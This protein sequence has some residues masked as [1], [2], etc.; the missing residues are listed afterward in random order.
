MGKVTDIA[1]LE[2]LYGVPAKPSLTKVADHVT[3][4]YAKW[5]AA[6]RLCILSTVG[7]DGTNGSPR[8]DDG[9]VVQ[10]ADP[11]TLLMPDWRGNNRMDCLR[12][13]VADGR[14]SLMFIVRGSNNVIRVNGTAEVTI[15]A[16]VIAGFDDR[17]R[18]PRSVI[19]VRVA[20]VY[21]QCARALMRAQTWDGTDESTGLPSL[22]EILTEAEAG[23]DGATYDATWG[24]RA[25]ETM[26]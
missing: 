8:G 22:G 9:P 26:W 10:F 2:A 20:Q 1:Q 23:F 11:K 13:I 5:I 14:V 24:A 7:P 17:G 4:L 12:N 25:K 3:P 18:K 21:I 19:V 16:S 6:S 15:D